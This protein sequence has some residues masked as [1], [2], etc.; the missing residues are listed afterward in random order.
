MIRLS[1]IIRTNRSPTMN[2]PRI[3]TI[4]DEPRAGPARYRII[5]NST[6]AARGIKM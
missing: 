6:R 2:N 1:L 3:V 4:R 5:I